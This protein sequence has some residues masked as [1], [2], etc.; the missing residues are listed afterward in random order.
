MKIIKFIPF[1]ALLLCKNVAAE[2]S[3]EG[4]DISFNAGI[5]S[6][7]SKLSDSSSS[8][9]GIGHTNNSARVSA[10]YT[11]LLSEKTTIA[12]STSYSLTKP[13]IVEEGDYEGCNIVCGASYKL[14]DHY[15]FY[16]EPGY[17]VNENTIVYLKAGYHTAQAKV[18]DSKYHLDGFSFGFGSKIFLSSK[19][20]TSIEVEKIDFGSEKS[21]S[22]KIEH[23]SLLGTIGL[24][25]M[26]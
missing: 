18:L 21:G 12:I 14:K 1:F 7:N 24:G 13:K 6:L 4:F 20:F 23:E 8:L 17:L 11:K 16:V 5:Q 3:V 22:T 26:F 9:D 2:N 10:R 15:A 25:Y 19:I